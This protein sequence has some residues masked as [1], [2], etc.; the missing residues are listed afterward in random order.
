MD[1]A[2]LVRWFTMIAAAGCGLGM[3]WG[4]LTYKEEVPDN[5]VP[6]HAA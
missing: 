6:L 5:V 1:N 4:L 2:C 3:I